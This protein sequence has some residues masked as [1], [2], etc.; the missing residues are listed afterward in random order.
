VETYA[1]KL[2][3]RWDD[4]AAVTAMGQMP[5]F[6]DFLKTS[7][8]WD[9]FVADCPLR[10][11]SPNAPSQVDVLGTLLMSVLAGQSRYAHIT[12]LRGDG[13]NPELLG[14]RKV[15]SEDSARRAFK[16]AS[17]EENLQWLRR[18]L[19]QTYEPLLEHAWVLDL[20]ST[21]KPLY[22]KQEKAVKGYNPT[23]PGR[24]SHVMHTYL[25]AQLRLVLGAEVQAGNEAASSHAQPGFW[26]YFDTL[27]PASRPVF[28]RGDIGWGSERMMQEAEQRDQPYFLPRRGNLWV[29]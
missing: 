17:A 5:V 7:G 4:S 15:M 28:L 20:D 13:V 8:L 24:P 19:R 25:I 29:S 9:G 18:H 10:Y 12:G 22:G 3:I 11:T 14:M 1:G 23:K 26:A 21:V 2:R 16:Q 27:P 6:I